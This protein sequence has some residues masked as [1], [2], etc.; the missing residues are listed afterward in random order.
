METYTRDDALAA[1]GFG[2]VQAFVPFYAGMGWA[3]ESMEL[4]LLSFVGPLL[5][6]EWK[7]LCPR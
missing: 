1:M 5:R 3:A 2:K 7:N 6:E 4:N